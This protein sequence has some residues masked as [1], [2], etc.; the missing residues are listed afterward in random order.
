MFPIYLQRCWCKRRGCIPHVGDKLLDGVRHGPRM[1]GQDRPPGGVFGV[2]GQGAGGL[3]EPGG[4]LQ[5][6]PSRCYDGLHGRK[7]LAVTS[8]G[9]EQAIDAMVYI[10][11]L[12][13]TLLILIGQ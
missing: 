7:A 5:H 13:N 12:L 2:H 9:H 1:T 6:G 3:D 4:A 10:P 11:E 8:R